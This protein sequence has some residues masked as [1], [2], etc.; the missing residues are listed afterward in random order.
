MDTTIKS[1]A[2]RFGLIIASVGIFYTLMAYLVNLELLVNT[3]AG[4]GLWALNMVLL[5][6]AITQVKKAFGGYISFK[7]AFST[8]I[9]TYIISAL[10]SSVFGILLFSVID[11]EAAD[12]VQELI[13]ETTV[14]M[15][16]R[17]GAPED[18]IT[19]QVE[20]LE[21]TNQ[22]SASNQVRGFF[23]GIVLYA[24]IGLI[25]AAVMKKNKPEF[26]DQ[27]DDSQD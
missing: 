1:T 8:F 5:I 9:L 3:F 17:F 19:E 27:L 20:Q 2:S 24:I 25:V 26:I 11:P 13:I 23:T 12:R 10:V 6:V 7:E 14:N 15:M 21:S 4:L 16:E 18:S 22:F